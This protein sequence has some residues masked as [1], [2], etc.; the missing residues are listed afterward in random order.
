[1]KK[2]PIGSSAAKN[3]GQTNVSGMG[4]SGQKAATTTVRAPSR[5]QRS[6]SASGT[7]PATD[8]TGSATDKG[9]PKPTVASKK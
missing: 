4:I 5:E 7:K 1:M 8:R 9:R 6:G 3:S 2:A